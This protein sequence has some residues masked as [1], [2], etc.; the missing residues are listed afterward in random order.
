MAAQP[1]LPART[2]DTQWLK[3]IVIVRAIQLH[4][5]GYSGRPLMYLATNYARR[6]TSAITEIN[7]TKYNLK[8]IFAH[9]ITIDT[10]INTPPGWI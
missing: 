6:M 10:E 4:V 1:K 8:E 5:D 7:I 9:I 3:S 2:S